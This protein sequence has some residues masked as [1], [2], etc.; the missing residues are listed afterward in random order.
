MAGR[1]TDVIRERKLEEGGG[2]RGAVGA[3]LQWRHL[4]A[5]S[6]TIR[7]FK[8]VLLEPTFLVTLVDLIGRPLPASRYLFETKIR[9]FMTV[10]GK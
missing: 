10:V 1:K 8:W 3:L 2:G 4:V 9:K 7:L 6:R 5:T